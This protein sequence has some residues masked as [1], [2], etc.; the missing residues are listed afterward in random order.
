[1]STLLHIILAYTVLG[2]GNLILSKRGRS[3]AFLGFVFHWEK[4]IIMKHTASTTA[5]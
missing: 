1:M 4:M 5:K 3:H 2:P